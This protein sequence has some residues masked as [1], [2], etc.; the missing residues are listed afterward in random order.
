M[1]G[2]WPEAFLDENGTY[3]VD[4][5]NGKK[6]SRLTLL[7]YLSDGFL[8]GGTTFYGAVPGRAGEGTYWAFPKSQHC[9]TEAG[10]C[11]PYIAI[12]K[13]DTFFLSYQHY[14]WTAGVDLK[15]AERRRKYAACHLVDQEKTLDALVKR[16][17]SQQFRMNVNVCPDLACYREKPKV[18][19]EGSR[20]EGKPSSVLRDELV[21]EKHDSERAGGVGVLL[22]DHDE[23]EH[24]RRDRGGETKESIINIIPPVLI[25]NDLDMA[26]NGGALNGYGAE[27]RVI[28]FASVWEHVDGVSRTMKR[29]AHHL[30]ERTDSRVFVMSPDLVESD[31]REAATHD[32]YH[33]VDV[34]H[35]PMPGRGEYKMAAPLQQRQ[36]HQMETFDPHVV[37]VAAPDMLGHSAVRWAAENGVCSV[38]S[39]HTAYDTYLQYY[40]VGV[41]AAPLRQM[42][43]GFYTSCDVVATPSYAA[44]EHLSEMVRVFPIYHV[45][46]TDRPDYRL[47]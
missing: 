33:V 24:D 1:D 11:C 42:L 40:R 4:N 21:N 10:D 37:H 14:Q 43:S 44:A 12:Y 22:A 32:K 28:I 23:H 15:L 3:V 35:I 27:R 46:P 26:G 30:R 45:P 18:D 25:L 34:P 39:Y 16:L 6:R 38:C 19:S 31:F 36:R 9:F 41:L 7:M 2:S 13:T 47:L 17:E 8:G 20:A 5:S 29:L